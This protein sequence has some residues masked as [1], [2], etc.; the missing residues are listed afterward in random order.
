LIQRALHAADALR[1]AVPD[2]GHLLHMPTHIDVLCGLYKNVIDW[3][4][5]AIVG[6]RKFV[7]QRGEKNFYSLYRCHN[8]HFKLY[9]AMFLDQ[10]EP[11]LAAA[12]EMITNP[13][14][15]LLRV[16]SPPMA[17]WLEG[18]V[19]MKQHVLIR[20]GKWREI[21]A[22]PLPKDQR[23]CCTTTAMLHYVKAVAHA[24]SGN[25][26]AAEEEAGHFEVARATVPS[27]RYVFNNI[28]LGILTVA[29]EMMMGEI[30]YRKGQF[31]TAFAHLRKSVELDDGLPY[32][33]PWGWMR[34]ASCA[35]RAPAGAEP[36]RGG[37]VSLSR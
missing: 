4:D 24:A 34:D 37:G 15:A 28:C 14:E 13:P 23:L 2:A 21:V 31:D 29:A 35:R 22:Q 26:A 6:D 3:N 12:E 18:I 27:T 11:A 7:K 36:R 8:Y 25:I 20:F 17:N 33:E 30:A 5:R 16:E 9:G 1:T 10:Y 32:D 19:P